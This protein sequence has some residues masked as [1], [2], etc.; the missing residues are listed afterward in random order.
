[1]HSDSDTMQVQR[2]VPINASFLPAGA[3]PI[4]NERAAASLH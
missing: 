1:M 2:V 4:L 3:K